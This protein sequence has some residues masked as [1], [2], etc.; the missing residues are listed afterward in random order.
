MVSGC[1]GWGRQHLAGVGG[2]GN[3]SLNVS[4]Q[5]L[6]ALRLPFEGDKVVPENC[7]TRQRRKVLDVPG[8]CHHA[9]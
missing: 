3:F 5:D 6:A 7:D 8:L 9:S 4:E 1:C 2:L